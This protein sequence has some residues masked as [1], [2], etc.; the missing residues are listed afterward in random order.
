MSS[1]P[2][3]GRDAL[4]LTMT[5]EEHALQI[6]PALAAPQVAH[7]DLDGELEPPGVQLMAKEM[8]LEQVKCCSDHLCL[9]PAAHFPTHLLLCLSKSSKTVLCALYLGCFILIN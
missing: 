4:C 9:L 5:K 2:W 3:Y 1:P 7:R 6:N 8:V